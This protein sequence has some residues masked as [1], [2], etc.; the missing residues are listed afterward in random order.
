METKTAHQI[1]V[2]NQQAADRNKVHMDEAG[3]KIAK[4]VSG[5]IGQLVDRVVA[6]TM[7]AAIVGGLEVPVVPSV[8]ASTEVAPAVVRL[9]STPLFDRG[10]SSVPTGEIPTVTEP[11][12]AEPVK[13]AK[14]AAKAK[15]GKRG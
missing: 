7:P 12:K 15:R 5:E 8:P 14:A 10:P 9:E 11:A 6:E 13:K 3:K 2:E 4:K 1:A